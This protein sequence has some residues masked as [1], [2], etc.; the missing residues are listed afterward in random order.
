MFNTGRNNYKGFKNTEINMD[1]A[2]YKALG[3]LSN[4]TMGD[5]EKMVLANQT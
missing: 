2:V 1:D 4:P 5:F 3:H